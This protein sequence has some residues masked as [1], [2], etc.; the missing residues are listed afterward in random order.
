MP[1][2]MVHLGTAREYAS[3]HSSILNCPE[4]YLGSISPDAI[5][6]RKNIRKE[7]KQNT[8]LCVSGDFNINKVIKFLKEKEKKDNYKF[9]LGYGMHILTDIIWSNT[10]YKKFELKYKKEFDSL[11]DIKDAYYNDTD[12][13]DFELY[14]TFNWRPIVW[15]LLKKAKGYDVDGILSSD[16]ITAWNERTLNW[17]NCGKSNHNDPIKYLTVE[18]LIQF[19]RSTAKKIKEILVTEGL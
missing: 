16:E 17:Y 15:D 5:H 2:P 7:D 3:N 8:H 4:Y 12:Q 13:L 6:M 18:D 9:I 11:H 14:K 10:L 19:T 1:L